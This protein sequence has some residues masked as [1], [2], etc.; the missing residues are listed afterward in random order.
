MV[1]RLVRP[2]RSEVGKVG[3]RGYEGPR[4]VG[5]CRSQDEYCYYLHFTDEQT[6]AEKVYAQCATICIRARN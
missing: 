2:G 4:G 5:L 6:K 3:M 1:R